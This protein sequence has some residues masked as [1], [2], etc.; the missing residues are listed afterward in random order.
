MAGIVLVGEG[1][2]EGRWRGTRRGGMIRE[3]SELRR[4]EAGRDDGRQ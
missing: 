4:R 1:G 3:G 2:K